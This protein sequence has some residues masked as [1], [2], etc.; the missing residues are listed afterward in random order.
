MDGNF[1]IYWG[2]VSQFDAIPCAC[3][4]YELQKCKYPDK[5]CYDP[6]TAYAYGRK[7]KS[8]LQSSV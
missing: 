1:S 2:T 5:S 6:V 3:S 4:V 8:G 7:G